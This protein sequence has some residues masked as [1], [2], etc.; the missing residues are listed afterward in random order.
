[1]SCRVIES[2]GPRSVVEGTVMGS[3]VAGPSASVCERVN[4]LGLLGAV[5]EGGSGGCEDDVGAASGCCI[6]SAPATASCLESCWSGC[7]CSVRVL[8]VEGSRLLI[9]SG[10]VDVCSWVSLLAAAAGASASCEAIEGALQG[11]CI[12]TARPCTQSLLSEV[13]CG[14]VPS[15][16]SSQWYKN[17]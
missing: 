8:G 16:L 12:P 2:V 4:G 6:C 14:L 11:E 3:S 9:S 13:C 1:M 7:D 5:G 17:T 10:D 15:R